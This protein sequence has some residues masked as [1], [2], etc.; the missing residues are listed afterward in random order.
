MFGANTS[1]TG[2]APGA[3]VPTEELS[4]ARSERYAAPLLTPSAPTAAVNRTSRTSVV[5]IPAVFRVA[6]G[7]LTC[8]STIFFKVEAPVDVA[9]VGIRTSACGLSADIGADH[10]W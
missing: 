8:S 5:S 2:S 1:I 3:A 6:T 9:D 4:N 10:V 7:T